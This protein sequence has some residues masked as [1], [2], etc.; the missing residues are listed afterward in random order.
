[1]NVQL[2]PITEIALGLIAI[3]IG[4]EFSLLKIKRTGTT[5]LVLTLCEAIFAF[6]FVT[7]ILS[8][9]GINWAIA[10]LLGAISAATAPAATVVIIRDLRARGEFVDILYGVVALDDAVCV[11]LFGL[12][13]TISAPFLTGLTQSGGLFGGILHAV[14]KILLSFLIG[15][16]GGIGIHFMTRNKYK[17]NE[18]LL[19]SL[20]LLLLITAMAS[21][22]HLSPLIANMAMGAAVINLSPRNRRVFTI[23]EPLTPPVFALF[24]ILAGTELNVSVFAKGT[25]VWLGL[26]YLLS[27]FAGKSAGIF[28]GGWMTK[29]AKNIRKFLSFC[30]F[31]QAGV[32]IGLALFVQTSPAVL[33][34]PVE[35]QNQFSLIVNVVLLSVFIN[36]LVGPMIS[37]FGL[38]RGLGR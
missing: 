6:L 23:L 11:I 30:L 19:I 24:F 34:A 2:M 26:I 15:I 29:T 38:K 25:V 32:A 13:F 18:I 10:L 37:K 22:F 27:R 8:L 12:V 31:P 17:I 33:K 16:A 5:I 28:L 3:T 14:I 35:V 9:L 20:S 7:C 21:A 4:G 1:M 36:E